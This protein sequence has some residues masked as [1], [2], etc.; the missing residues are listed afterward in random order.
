[1]AKVVPFKAIRPKRDKAGLIA[2][3][4]YLSYSQ[5]TLKE[6][7]ENNPYT[8]LHII[9]PDYK[10]QKKSKGIAKF[11]LV[12]KKYKEFIKEGYLFQDKKACYYIYLQENSQYRYIGII[13]G[14]SV[15]DY[16]NNQIKKHEHTIT[17]REKMFKDYLETTGFNADPVL[18]CH[19]RDLAIKKIIKKYEKLRSEYEFTT[20][21]KTLHKLW[22]VNNMNDI[23]D[24]SKIFEKMNTLYIADGHHRCASSALLSKNKK[25][26][27]YFMSFLIDENQL[28]VTSFNRL[29][30]KLNNLTT[31][32]LLTQIK[33]RFNIIQNKSCTPTKKDEIGMYLEGKS[34]L[35]KLRKE[36]K[37]NDCVNKLDPAILSNNILQPILNIID[38]KTDKNIKFISGKVNF[39]KIKE[40]IDNREYQVAFI[41]KPIPIKAIKEVADQNKFMPPK[42]TYVEPKLR[43]G[44]TIYPLE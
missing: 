22:V 3:R 40:L 34:Y 5:K 13:A 4:S 36:N 37:E 21:N 19:P 1:M 20:T 8:F 7:L 39:E 18:L 28:H 38:E 35:L 43:S 11:K 24:I 14:S 31:N 10:S 27:N 17:K 26:N 23:R 15:K 41:L 32:Q 12:K 44:L 6:K 25:N 16:I 42:S 29:I 30:K 9:N 33:D 2:S